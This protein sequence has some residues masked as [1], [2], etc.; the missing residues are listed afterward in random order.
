MSRNKKKSDIEIRW[1]ELMSDAVT[2]S[3]ALPQIGERDLGE[4]VAWKVDEW[5]GCYPSNWKGVVV[6]EA[7]GHPAKFSSKLIR[8]IYEHVVA[9][10]WVKPGDKVIDPFGGVA[11]GAL[12]AMRLGLDWTGVELEERFWKIGN[13]NIA[14]WNQRYSG[15]PRWGGARLLH[16]DSRK[17]LAVVDGQLVVSSPPYAETTVTENRQFRSEAEPDRPGAKD[18]R[19]EAGAAYGESDGQLGVMPAGKFE[20]AISS[21]PFLQSE[22]GTPEPKAGG[23]IDARLQERHAAGNAAAHGYGKSEGQLSS[24]NGEGFKLAVSSPPYVES[25]GHGG[26]V[27]EI[28][29]QKGTGGDLQKYGNTPGQLADADDFWMAARVIVEQVYSALESGGH[30]CWVVK[31][32]VKAKQVV[33][34]ADR[35]RQLCEAVGF[36]TLH[37]H[38]AMLVHHKGKQGMLEGGVHEVKTESKSFFRRLAEKKGSPRIDWEVVWCMRKP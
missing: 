23:V 12:E 21:P 18:L 9:E 20:L 3:P 36:E 16:G 34:F 5:R 8:R 26:K 10:G 7:M 1:N 11:L 33:P 15:M 24:M 19:S 2:P 14:I 37:E 32:Y 13:E 17:L 35:W 28:D 38:R 27:S 4:G 30:A 6:T 25:P 31:D 22:G 29:I